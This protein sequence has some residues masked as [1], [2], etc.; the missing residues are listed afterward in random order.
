LAEGVN[1]VLACGRRTGIE[2]PYPKDSRRL[3]CLTWVGSCQKDSK[4]QKSG[5]FMTHCVFAV[6]SKGY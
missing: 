6:A 3:L 4:Q 2:N 5:D 1:E